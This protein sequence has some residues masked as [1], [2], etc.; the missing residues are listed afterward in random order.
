MGRVC[1]FRF[2]SL[3]SFPSYTNKKVKIGFPSGEGERYKS[4]IPSRGVPEQDMC[5][6]FK[7]KRPSLMGVNSQDHAARVVTHAARGVQR[8]PPGPGYNIHQT[9]KQLVDLR[10]KLKATQRRRIT[11]TAQG[12]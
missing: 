4:T 12:P 7:G 8:L 2:A 6:S 5:T 3:S 1:L 11:Q 10:Q 9:R